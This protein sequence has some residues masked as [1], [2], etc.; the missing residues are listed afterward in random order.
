MSVNLPSSCVGREWQEGSCL[1]FD[2]SYEHETWN[3]TDDERV[4]LLAGETT[5]LS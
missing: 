3:T 5:H 2:D 1:L 4:I